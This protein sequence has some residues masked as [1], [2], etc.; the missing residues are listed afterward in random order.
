M[1]APVDGI[2]VPKETTAATFTYH[3][4][5]RMLLKWLRS[6]N[7]SGTDWGEGRATSRS[8]KRRRGRQST[9]PITTPGTRSRRLSIAKYKQEKKQKLEGKEYATNFVYSL[10][11]L[12]NIQ[13]RYSYRTTQQHFATSCHKIWSLIKQHKLGMLYYGL[14]GIQNKYL[15]GLDITST[16]TQTINPDKVHC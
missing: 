8:L 3:R 14:D 11:N 2:H 9:K 7:H 1:F 10:M 4:R 12:C 15:V 6:N 13:E 16:Y 5:G